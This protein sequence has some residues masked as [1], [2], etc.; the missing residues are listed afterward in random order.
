[1][2]MGDEEDVEE[3]AEEDVEEDVEGWGARDYR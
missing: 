1:M 3:D 2:K